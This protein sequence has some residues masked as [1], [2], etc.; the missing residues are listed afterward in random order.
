MLL[1]PF[2]GKVVVAIILE[3]NNYNEQITDKIRRIVTRRNLNIVTYK[4]Q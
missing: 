3:A 2:R 4:M 1:L